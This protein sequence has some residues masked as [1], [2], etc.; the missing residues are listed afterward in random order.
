MKFKRSNDLELI[1]LGPSY[2]TNDEYEDCLI[3]L[4]RIGKY[5]GGNRASFKQFS[6]HINP[7]KIL[8]VGCGGG[9]FTLLLGKYFPQSEVIGIDLSY[10][11]IFFAKKQLGHS[12]VKNVQ[13]QVLDLNQI[14]KTHGKIDIITATLVCHHLKDAELIEFLKQSY[15][16]ACKSV[17]INDLHRNWLA[18]F[19]FALIAKGF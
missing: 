12:L 16:I 9:S 17:I 6:K 13:F 15:R 2:Y 7:E 5:L 3:Q 1:D 19:G 11:A 8:D 10:Q 18:Y 4:G 14:E